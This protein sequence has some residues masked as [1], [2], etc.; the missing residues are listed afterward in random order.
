MPTVFPSGD[1]K[2]FEIYTNKA[3]KSIFNIT[4]IGILNSSNKDTFG[5]NLNPKKFINVNSPFTHE[6]KKGIRDEI[7]GEW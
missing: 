4:T 5:W 3:G 1:Y 6:V 2:I 7:L